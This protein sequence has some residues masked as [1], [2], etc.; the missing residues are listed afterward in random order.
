MVSLTTP[1]VAP[2]GKFM[3]PLK[4]PVTVTVM[5]RLDGRSVRL[6]VKTLLG[7]ITTWQSANWILRITLDSLEHTSL[8]S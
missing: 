4:T 8:A 6:G 3:G 5:L 1:S 2:N 7:D